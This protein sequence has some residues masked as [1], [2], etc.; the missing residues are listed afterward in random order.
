MFLE[1]L[2]RVL[3]YFFKDFEV[4]NSDCYPESYVIIDGGLVKYEI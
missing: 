4:L 1:I 2:N 3:L